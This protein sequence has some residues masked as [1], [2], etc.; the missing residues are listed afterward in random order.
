MSSPRRFNNAFAGVEWNGYAYVADGE[1]PRARTEL[2][3]R[4]SILVLKRTYTELW[5]KDAPPKLRSVIP[6]DVDNIDEVVQRA[7]RQP[8]KALKAVF[9]AKLPQLVDLLIEEVSTGMK[10]VVWTVYRDSCEMLAAALEEALE[11][12]SMSALRRRYNLSLWATHGEASDIERV[13][14]ARE[15]REHDGGGFFAVNVDAL[16]EA[17]SLKMGKLGSVWYAQIHQQAGP[18]AQSENRAYHPD[19]GTLPINY[20]V[21]RKS[22]EE[23][24]IRQLL[25]RIEVMAKVGQ[26]KDAEEL[27]RALRL[28]EQ[29]ETIEDY[30]NRIFGRMLVDGQASF[31]LDDEGSTE[32]PDD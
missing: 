30:Q 24:A 22:P 11:D 16:P 14:M 23:R 9:E 21:V 12:R 19:L 13:D 28:E 8:D 17:A 32:L 25:P 29:Q 2:V 27:A 6:L 5:G 15:F 1:T 20:P 31:G 4:T 26:D 18:M 7:G 3:K 10:C